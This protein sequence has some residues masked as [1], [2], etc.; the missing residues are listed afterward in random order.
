M[1]GFQDSKQKHLYLDP[2]NH[3]IIY[4]IE[5]FYLSQGIGPNLLSIPRFWIIEGEDTDMLRPHRWHQG[6]RLKRYFRTA[7]TIS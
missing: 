3:P 1:V 2:K 5:W 4:R 7:E 6:H